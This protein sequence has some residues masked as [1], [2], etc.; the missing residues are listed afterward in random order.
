MVVIV[1]LSKPYPSVDDDLLARDVGSLWRAELG[2]HGRDLLDVP[3][4]SQAHPGKGGAPD[5][6]R[7]R[8]LGRA[9]HK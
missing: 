4:P 8:Y 1:F 7:V 9:K 6:V 3:F 5:V 2:R